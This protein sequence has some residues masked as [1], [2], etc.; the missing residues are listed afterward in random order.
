MKITADGISIKKSANYLS[1]V[2]YI[3]YN[4]VRIGYVVELSDNDI[5]ANIV[6]SD[7]IIF[8][9]DILYYICELSYLVNKSLLYFVC[10]LEFIYLSDLK[11]YIRA[12]KLKELIRNDENKNE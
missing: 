3:L 8:S 10:G 6:P 5:Y 7:D 1:T 12:K 2:Y 9:R 4:D 11:K